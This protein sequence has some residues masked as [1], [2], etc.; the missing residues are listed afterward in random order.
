MKRNFSR[1]RN[2]ARSLR[3]RPLR[4]EL[5]EARQLLAVITVDSWFD[6]S[7]LNGEVTLREAIEA[8]NT[9]TSVDGSVAGNGPDT[10]VFDPAL[11]GQTIHLFS[12][13]TITRTL[14]IDATSLYRGVTI[15]ARQNSRVLN[16]DA[17]NGNLT[18]G[19]LNI[20]G[21]L[22]AGNNAIADTTYSGGGIRFVSAGTL[23]INQS[24]VFDNHTSGQRAD[25]G[26]IFTDTGDVVLTNSTLSG[27]RTSGGGA[28]G[29]GLHTTSGSVTIENSTVTENQT[30]GINADGG[31]IFVSNSSVNPDFIL[32]NSIVSGN[33]VAANSL[34]PDV[35]PD[36]NT[37]LNINYSL[38]GDTAGTGIHGAT[39]VGN[40]LDVDAQL[41]PLT[42]N[43]GH[44]FSHAP[45]QLSPIVDAGDPFYGGDDFDQ[46]GAPFVRRYGHRVDIGAFEAQNLELVVT[47]NRDENDGD[48]SADS[49]SLREAVEMTN[50][51]PNLSAYSNDLIRFDNSLSGST[52]LLS[53]EMRITGNLNINASELAD[54]MTIDG[55][56]QTRIINFGAPDG[57]TLDGNLILSGLILTRG[58]TTQFDLPIHLPAGGGG[59]RFASTGYLD[60]VETEIRDCEVEGPSFDGGAITTESGNVRVLF[61]TISGNQTMGAASR[62]GGIHTISGYVAVLDSMVS[63]NVAAGDLGV[64]A[65]GGAIYSDSGDVR[66][67]RSMISGN[68]VDSE[69]SGGAIAAK[70]GVVAFTDS[71][72]EDNA[73]FG[74]NG[75]GGCV[76]ASAGEVVLTRST[77]SGNST[78]GENSAGGGIYSVSGDVHLTMSTVN[79][80]KTVGF[81]ARGG[82][83]NALVGDI[84]L[85]DSTVSGNHTLGD[86]SQGGGIN[87]RSDLTLTNST[88]SGNYTEG[89]FSSGGG[90]HASE[91]VRVRNSTIKDNWVAGTSA[92][93]GGIAIS[94]ASNDLFQMLNSVVAENSSTFGA[95]PDLL[96][97]PRAFVPPDIQYSLIGDTTG[98]GFDATSG[99]GN[100]LDT[101]SE[102]GP[103]RGNGGH[104]ETHAPLTS[105]PVIDAGDPNA[106]AG[107][108]DIPEF[109]QR[110]MGFPRIV[111]THMDM[112]AIEVQAAFASCDFDLDLD[113]DVDDLDAMVADIAAGANKTLFDLTGDGYVDTLDRDLWLVDA[114]GQ[115]L[116]SANAYLLGDA[117][118]DGA[119]DAS[120]FNIWNSHK[121]TSTPAWSAG[122]FSADGVVDISD[123]NIWNGN[124]FQ[125][126][127]V[128]RRFTG[129]F[130][131]VTE[132]ED[133]DPIRL[134]TDGRHAL[135][136]AVFGSHEN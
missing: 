111:G 26:G 81:N 44:A 18:L 45:G 66:I 134:V 100:V 71:T 109:D 78:Y 85:I 128:P 56:H 107:Q 61:S 95:G 46:R 106:V 22:T 104:T 16:F 30:R 52:I 97:N 124:K 1:S 58:R 88:V 34:L 9:D 20:T 24:A 29:G 67:V 90:I 37:A 13:L 117:N 70:S 23:T 133:E 55:Q 43:G 40:L 126:A 123:F 47:T 96:L 114:G 50:A 35:F 69:G 113:C 8:A 54:P 51:S 92:N 72:C 33:S 136:D 89:D 48:F 76:W 53:E 36:P 99:T 73:T 129:K 75:F 19:G 102:L 64:S 25:G 38:I 118:L 2:L 132:Y 116:P 84:E 74:M 101:S 94:S 68:R 7:S 31:G 83:I 17:T 127:D 105:S 21:G 15:D 5:L 135:A 77:L 119:V 115:N 91:T 41:N 112:G 121:F 108:N 130:D 28:E 98:S 12:E 122:D 57:S 49:L 80:N 14:T 3:R 82:G 65:F 27:N 60:L 6:N 79:G 10:I 86:F 110:Q 125:N 87:A 93:G 59:V 120:D 32:R 63:D 11:T 103:L 42:D 62:G 131:A 39:G 4:C